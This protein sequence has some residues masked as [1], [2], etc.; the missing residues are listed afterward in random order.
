M[1]VTDVI[2]RVKNSSMKD[3]TC[4]YGVTTKKSKG[5]ENFTTNDEN[6][7]IFYLHLIGYLNIQKSYP[8]IIL[9]Y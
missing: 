3:Y 6:M 7:E 2:L 1:Y 5:F 8:I 4:H 9:Y